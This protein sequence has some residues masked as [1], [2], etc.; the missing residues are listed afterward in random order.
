MFLFLLS[1]IYSLNYAC[2]FVPP[3]W[4]YSFHPRAAHEDFKLSN[5]KKIVLFSNRSGDNS[6]HLEPQ[7]TSDIPCLPSIGQSSFAGGETT[8]NKSGTIRLDGN[9]HAVGNVGSDRFELQY[10]CKVCET[11]N[12]HRVSRLGECNA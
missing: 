2:A 9:S 8:S 10:T 3:G 5:Q 11:R 6:E 7:K 1:V 4:K 12:S